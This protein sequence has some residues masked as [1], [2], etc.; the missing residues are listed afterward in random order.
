MQRVKISGFGGQGIITSSFIVGKA[1]S[2]FDGKCAAMT[3]DY[4]PEAR[5]GS[6]SSQVVIDDKE[7]DY[8]LVDE[9]DILIAMSQ[10]GYDKYLPRLID[11]G[12]LCFDADLVG[13]TQ[14]HSRI[15][16]KGI[17]ATRI[18][19][20]L[21]KKIVANIVILG[22]A[23][24]Q[25]GFATVQAMKSSIEETVPEKFLDLNIKAFDIGYNYKEE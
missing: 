24:A 3:Q 20:Q 6:C 2:I 17:P 18:A 9:S 8:P 13:K 14:N 21:G 1:V 23:T 7:V 4:G 15:N 5:G 19:E 25:T 16:A 10:E 12:T 22:F 11:G